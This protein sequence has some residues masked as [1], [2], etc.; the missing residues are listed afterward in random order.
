MQSHSHDRHD[1]LLHG[2]LEARSIWRQTVF[3]RDLCLDVRDP[4][5]EHEVQRSAIRP[6]LRREVADELSIGSKALTARSLEAALR[7]EVGVADDEVVAHCM[8]PDGLQEEAL[9]RAIAAHEE[10]EGGASL[11][12]ELQV[13]EQCGNL[14]FAADR[15]IGEADTRNDAAFEGIDDDSG[16]ALRHARG[17]LVLVTHAQEPF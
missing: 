15:D 10:A 7:G 16:N 1:P 3:H 5:V 17:C 9:A 6:C 4:A 2:S 8:V 11:L 14:A 12:H 13:M